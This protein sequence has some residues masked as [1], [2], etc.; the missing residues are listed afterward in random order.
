VSPSGGG[1]RGIRTLEGVN[2][3][4]RF[5]G[6]S[7][8]PL[9][10]ATGTSLPTR[11]A[12]LDPISEPSRGLAPSPTEEEGPAARPS[13]GPS[14]IGG[15][16]YVTVSVTRWVVVPTVWSVVILAGITKVPRFLPTAS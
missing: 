13:A 14:S 7:L 3:P 2:P 1:G 8:R 11:R 12:V 16:P 9:G 6:V 15:W 4:T 5:P 10:Q